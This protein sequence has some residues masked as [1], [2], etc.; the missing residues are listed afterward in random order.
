[1]RWVATGEPAGDG[2]ALEMVP[3]PR[4]RKADGQR[5]GGISHRPLKWMVC[6]RACVY[7]HYVQTKLL[8]ILEG[9][10]WNRARESKWV[11][12]WLRALSDHSCSFQVWKTALKENFISMLMNAIFESN[13]SPKVVGKTRGCVFFLAVVYH[14]YRFQ[15]GFGT[16]YGN[17]SFPVVCTYGFLRKF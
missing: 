12:R 4:V 16:L 10:W 3:G 8:I 5:N 11:S 17:F 6:V 13:C 9:D 2:A 1:M 7:I 15:Q 14:F